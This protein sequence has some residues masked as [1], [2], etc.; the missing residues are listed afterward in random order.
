[1]TK[2]HHTVVIVLQDDKEHGRG[3]ARLSGGV[4]RRRC[5]TQVSYTDAWQVVYAVQRKRQ[6]VV[7]ELH[8]MQLYG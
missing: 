4:E 7:K 2:C 6:G 5:H 8:K 3:V 1:M